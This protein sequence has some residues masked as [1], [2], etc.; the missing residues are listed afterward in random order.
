MV[1]CGESGGEEMGAYPITRTVPKGSFLIL[2]PNILF[3]KAISSGVSSFANRARFLDMKMM[4][5]MHQLSSVRYVSNELLPR[6]RLQASMTRASL[7]F[8]PQYSLRSWVRRNSRGRVLWV[9]KEARRVEHVEAM[10]SMGVC[11]KGG[12]WTAMAS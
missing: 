12:S 9:R 10:L 6:S 2:G 1:Y 3:V 4:S 7:S 8:R 5:F 11:S